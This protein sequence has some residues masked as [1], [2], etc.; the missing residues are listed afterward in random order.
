MFSVPA[1]VANSAQ[2]GTSKAGVTEAAE[3][4]LKTY[5]GAERKRNVEGELR[6]RALLAE[7]LIERRDLDAAKAIIKG[8]EPSVVPATP[9]AREYQAALQ[10]LAKG[11]GERPPT[12]TR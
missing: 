10:R 11:L 9:R 5:L 1:A 12:T 3:T 4:L 6:A 7:I 2:A 8:V